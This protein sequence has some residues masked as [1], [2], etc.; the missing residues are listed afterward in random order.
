M[1]TN[2]LLKMKGRIGILSSEP[3]PNGANSDILDFLLNSDNDEIKLATAVY[4]GSTVN[5]CVY[6]KT[7]PSQNA[8]KSKRPR[9]G[10]NVPITF[11]AS[12]SPSAGFGAQLIGPIQLH[13][14]RQNSSICKFFQDIAWTF[15]CL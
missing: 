12:Y 14:K 8:P 9:I 10:R 1:N 13:V 6:V 3:E 5:L 4:F 15:F 2:L 11:S 7:S